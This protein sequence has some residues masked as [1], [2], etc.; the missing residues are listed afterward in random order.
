MTAGEKLEARG[1][2]KGMRR[3]LLSLLHESFPALPAE[4]EQRVLNATKAELEVWSR[5]VL[6]AKSLDDVFGASE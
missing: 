4:T 3:L 1:E 6:K 5:R 2:L